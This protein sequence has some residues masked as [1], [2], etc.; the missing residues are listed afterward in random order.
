MADV[1]RCWL[2]LMV[3]VVVVRAAATAQYRDRPVPRPHSHRHRNSTATD[4]MV[5]RRLWSSG[6]SGIAQGVRLRGRGAA[7][8]ATEAAA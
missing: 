5:H 1:G 3:V 4:A 2:T 7:L 6:G 8:C